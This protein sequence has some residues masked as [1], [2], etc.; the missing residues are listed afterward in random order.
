ML[1]VGGL[2]EFVEFVHCAIYF[3]GGIDHTGD[4]FSNMAGALL[5]EFVP[6]LRACPVAKIRFL[7]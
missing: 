1:L 5:W 7:F 4:Y 6:D 3:L 2:V